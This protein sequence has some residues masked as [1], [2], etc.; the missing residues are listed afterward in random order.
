MAA[1][2]WRHTSRIDTALTSPLEGTGAGLPDVINEVGASSSIRKSPQHHDCSRGPGGHLCGD[3]SAQTPGN[4]VSRNGIANCLA[5][6]QPHPRWQFTRAQKAI[7]KHTIPAGSG[8]LPGGGGESRRISQ[9][10]LGWEHDRQADR[11]SRPLLR[12]EA[13]MA[14]P[15]RVRIRARKPWVFARRRLLGWNVRFMAQTPGYRLGK[16]CAGSTSATAK[17]YGLRSR[18]V[19]W[20]S[21]VTDVLLPLS[22]GPAMTSVAV[23]FH[24]CGQLCG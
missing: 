7:G 6:D 12:R 21:R 17:A 18:W 10:V 15:A 16:I 13:R 24:I 5:D 9:P 20:G 2:T 1:A 4:P 19:K 8:A 23:L 14:R 11:R 3:G 22:G